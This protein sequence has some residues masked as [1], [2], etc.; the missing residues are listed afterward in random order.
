M[1]DKPV[2]ERNGWPCTRKP[3]ATSLSDPGRASS[4]DLQGWPWVAI[5]DLKDAS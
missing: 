1:G 2:L 5:W 4:L 3:G